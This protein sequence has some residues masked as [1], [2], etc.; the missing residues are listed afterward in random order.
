MPRKADRNPSRPG[1]RSLGTVLGIFSSLLCGLLL[2]SSAIQAEPRKQAPK[3]SAIRWD[4]EQPGCTF[5]TSPDGKYLY[6]L[7]SDDIGITLALDSQELEKVRHRHEPFFGVLLTVRDRSNKSIDVVP[8]IITL[9]FVKHSKIIQAALDPDNFSEKIQ[10][11]ADALDHQTA[12]AVEKH[13][14]QKESKQAYMRAFQK[15]TAELL[16]FVS[17]NSLRSSRLVPATPEVSGW[18]LFSTKNKWLGKW[19]KQEEFVLRIPLDGN[20]YEFPFKLPPRDGEL[21]LRKR[22]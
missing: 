22:E 12:F 17:K 18:V 21:L 20:I 2:S 6:G 14:D 5:S 1:I 16:E 11:D 8:E 9:E 15:D 10:N 13:P 7:W 3:L 4:E 19:K